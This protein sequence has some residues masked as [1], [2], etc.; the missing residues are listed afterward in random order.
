M[1]IQRA[2]I[3]PTRRIDLRRVKPGKGGTGSTSTP[4]PWRVTGTDGAIVNVAGGWV[5][6]GISE[7]V[8][9]AAAA[10]EVG[11]GTSGTP[12]YIVL[13][14]NYSNNTATI[15]TTATA[16]AGQSDGNY[17]RTTLHEVYRSGDNAVH[18]RTRRASDIDIPGFG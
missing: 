6:R 2:I 5:Q 1:I 17:Y 15:L 18:L 8:I 13:Q 16:T 4:L 9:V 12:W 7:R 14:Y 11:G 3:N 10:V